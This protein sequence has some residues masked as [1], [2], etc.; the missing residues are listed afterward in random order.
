MN[1]AVLLIISIV[2]LAVG[3]VL[4]GGWLAKQWGVDPSRKTP[5][6]ELE[7]GLDYVP[8]KAPVLMGHHFSSIAGAGPINGP[9]QAAVFGWV[10]V[11][12]W[13]LIGGIF[14]G[15]VHDF[16]ALFASLRHKGQSIGEI[17]DDSMGKT[18]KKLFITFGYLT[19][20]LV[21]AAF[22][23]IVA[24]TFGITTA[25]GAAVEGA[26]LAANQSTAMI[27]ILFIL[28]AIVF[29]FFVY[30]KNAPIGISSV[31]GCVGIIAVVFIGLN[32]HPIALT[33]NAWMWI[34][35]AY[36]LIASVTPV[37]ILLQ[38]RDYLSSFL[39]YFMIAA[40]IIA[41]IGSVVTGNSSFA[42][43]AMGDAA[44]KGT[45]VFTTGTAF[46]ALFV[47]IA[48]GAI[49]G[50]HSLVSS[51]T[52][53]KQLDNEKDAKPVAFGSMLIECVV[54]VIS[55]CAVG[56]VW[57]AAANGDYASPTQ[58]FAGGLSAMIG[59]F[60]PGAQN[61]MYQLLILAVSVFCLTSLDT[62]TR[63]ARY[64]FQEFFVENGQT[65]KDLT[66]YKK[67]LANPYVATAITVVLGVSLGMTGY[68]KIWP[69]F[70]AA[71]QLLAAIGLLAVCTWL[72][73]VG[74]NNKMFYIPMV[75][76]LAVTICSLV[77]TIQAKL[78]AYNSGAAD[79]W[80]LIQ[81]LIAILLVVLSV[82]LAVIGAK[83]L[84]QQFKNK[85]KKEAA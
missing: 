15:G 50:F 40:G 24:S 55:L 67:V 44:L 9:I 68:T 62:A 2:V 81:A 19:L 4:Y 14:F 56:F 35:G 28:L 21:V 13:V 41:I 79:V 3:Y 57:V 1:A 37:W 10:P 63:L 52:T 20:L 48:C 27:S 74:K 47:T 60:A 46:P 85:D 73:A 45:G 54:A 49:S 77:Q 22:S 6:H 31:I 11:L 51:G 53:A 25:A 34:L 17:I 5:A 75:F 78:T 32:F 23:S 7:D 65:V 70:G 29:G 36:I 61:M 82:I 71:N 84:I 18:A 59:S 16:G 12:L 83:T 80:A 30:R 43:P 8:A 66:G 38:P 58:V 39:L 64:M 69:L 42:I 76:M 33:Y 26:T 72:G